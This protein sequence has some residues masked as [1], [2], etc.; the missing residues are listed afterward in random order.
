N[1]TGV[2]AAVV[3][4][5]LEL[6]APDGRNIHIRTEGGIADEL[7][8]AAS[9]GDVDLI[10]TGK[11]RLTSAREF[12]FSDTSGALGMDPP[13]QTV[14]GNPGTALAGISVS[15]T[16]AATEAIRIVDTAL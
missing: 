4:G 10:V 6:T 13:V 9:D 8:L 16:A 15:S 1:Q 3:E 7:G 14:S 2:T 11:L 5:R 12:S